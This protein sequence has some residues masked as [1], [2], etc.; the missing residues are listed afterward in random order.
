MITELDV[1]DNE[2]PKD[3]PL[4]DKLVAQKTQEFLDCVF[5]AAQPAGIVTWGL[6]DNNTWVPIYYKR[7]DGLPNWPLPLDQD[8]QIKPMYS[9]V[10]EFMR[11]GA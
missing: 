8:M 9:V 4:R 11:C 1:I 10:S 7:Q 6:S 3:E 5:N 2:F